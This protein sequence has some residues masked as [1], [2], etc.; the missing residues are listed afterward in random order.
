MNQ[1]FEVRFLFEEGA[2]LMYVT[3]EKRNPGQK[4]IHYNMISAGALPCSNSSFIRSIY[5]ATWL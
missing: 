1:F 4:D 2:Y 5:G 3:D